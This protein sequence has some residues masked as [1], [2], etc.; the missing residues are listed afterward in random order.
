MSKFKVSVIV[1]TYNHGEW[2]AACLD[3]IITQKTN[4]KFEVLVGDDAST[5]GI[6]TNILNYYAKRFPHLIKAIFRPVNI[7]PDCNIFD[8]LEQSDGEYISHIDGDDLMLPDKLQIQSD[9]LDE[10]HDYT[11]VGHQ[12]YELTP[13]GKKRRFKVPYVGKLTITDLIC[14]GAVFWHSS[15][16]YRK[17]ASHLRKRPK[18]NMVI[19]YLL[20]IDHSLYGDAYVLP[21]YLGIYRQNVGVATSFR[22]RKSLIFSAMDSYD[23]ALENGVDKKLVEKAKVQRLITFAIDATIASD[24][25]AFDTAIELIKNERKTFL[26]KPE[27]FFKMRHLPLICKVLFK[28]HLFIT[29]IKLLSLSNNLFYFLKLPIFLKARFFHSKRKLMN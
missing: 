20:H 29:K 14:L 12:M 11:A 22:W 6:T 1:P 7:G 10:N 18:K 21:Y 17:S 3:S 25:L 2:L 13:S 23:Y 8:L 28:I 5:D 26:F 19:D 4:F 27:L 24:R 9:F 15:T 16:M